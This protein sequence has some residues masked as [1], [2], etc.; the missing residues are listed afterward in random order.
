MDEKLLFDIMLNAIASPI[1]MT[2]YQSS[3]GPAFV[4]RTAI[5][6]ETMDEIKKL[7]KEKNNG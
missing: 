3:A 1:D 5:L 6:K 2:E 4:V 7:Y